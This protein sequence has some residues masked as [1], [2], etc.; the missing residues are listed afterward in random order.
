MKLP[1]T[2]K[3]G[4]TFRVNTLLD[5][6]SI[7]C[8]KC[9]EIKTLRVPVAGV[10]EPILRS[11]PAAGARV[12]LPSWVMPAILGYLVLFCGEF[13]LLTWWLVQ[14]PRTALDITPPIAEVR[15]PQIEGIPTVATQTTPLLA[16]AGMPAVGIPAEAPAE[17]ATVAPG[18]FSEPSVEGSAE[19]TPS[20]AL[21]PSSVTDA[22]L[23]GVETPRSSLQL[24]EKPGAKPSDTSS[25]AKIE[26]VRRELAN[27]HFSLRRLRLDGEAP[28]ALRLGVTQVAHDDVGSILT[29]MGSGYQFTTIRNQDLLSYPTLRNFDVL[30][31]TCADLFVQDFQAAL[32]LRKFVE[33]G[34]TL[35]AS[36]LR[37]DLVAAA[38]PEFRARTPPRPGVPQTVEARVADTG[39]ESFLGRKAIP[40]TFEAPHWRPAVFDTSKTTVCL[41]SVY[42]NELGQTQI[43]PLLVKFHV[44]RGTVIFTSFHHT[45][46]DSQIVR[47]VL[48]YLVFASVSARSET[49]VR[50]LMH[51][52]DFAPADIR[53]AVLSAGQKHQ[54]SHQHAGGGLQIA[55]GFENQ[56]AKLRLLLR[57]PSGQTIEHEDQGIYLIDLP[58][59]EPGAWHF[60][61]TPVELPHAN[62]PILVAV[63]RPK[64]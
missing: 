10:P 54:G 9:F 19:G 47:K 29:K 18:E 21:E 25:P 34:G 49:R 17:A 53:P 5:G 6:T 58:N 44:K 46:N 1:V 16:I 56:G 11:G 8:P 7:P 61:V 3:C 62:F 63:G 30:F 32:P 20:L 52:H 26:T 31:L 45:N 59:A 14:P 57:S 35:Y 55:L 22:V 51:S 2:C 36:D 33:Q 64:S 27:V 12:L 37:A 60:E 42:R 50:D 38:F 43:A 40:L 41:K 28:R 15:S 13:I 23:A 4:E 24:H 48:D 39:L